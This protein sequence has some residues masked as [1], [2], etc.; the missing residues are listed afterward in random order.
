MKKGSLLY[1]VYWSKFNFFPSAFSWV[2]RDAT[3]LFGLPRLFYEMACSVIMGVF[4]K[5]CEGSVFSF[6]CMRGSIESA[7]CCV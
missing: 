5:V 6:Y 2:E 7:W 4:I 3:S 1:N